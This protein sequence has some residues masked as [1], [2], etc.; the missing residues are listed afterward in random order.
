MSVRRDWYLVGVKDGELK[1]LDALENWNNKNNIG[2]TYQLIQNYV[3]ERKQ[4]VVVE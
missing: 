4:K 2:K 1:E 3:K